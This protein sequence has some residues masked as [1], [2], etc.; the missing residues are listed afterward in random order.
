MHS[1]KDRHLFSSVFLCSL[2]LSVS[3]ACLSLRGL[4]TDPCIGHGER[5]WGQ[6]SDPATHTAFLKEEG[7]KIV[8][9]SRSLISKGRMTW[10]GRGNLPF[11]GG[12]KQ[13]RF[14]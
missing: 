5:V 10:R 8:I 13:R 9:C 4:E 14:G 1:F 3:M 12:C 7:M 6:V 2:C 11:A